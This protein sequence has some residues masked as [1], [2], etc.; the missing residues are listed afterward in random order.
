MMTAA[1]VDKPGRRWVRALIG[2][3]GPPRLIPAARTGVCTGLAVAVAVAAHRPD[4]GLVAV[5]GCFTSQYAPRD[6]GRRV[7]LTLTGIALSLSVAVLVAGLLSTHRFWAVVCTAVVAAIVTLLVPAL[8]VPPPGMAI[9]VIAA[10]VAT[11]LPSGHAIRNALLVFAAGCGCVVIAV[12]ETAVRTVLLRHTTVATAAPRLS[13]RDWWAFHIR[14]SPALLMAA[15]VGGTVLVAGFL[16]NA[17]ASA[18][19][20]SRSYWAMAAGAAA[21]GTGSHGA[22]VRLRVTHYLLGSCVGVIVAAAILASDPAPY[23]IAILLGLLMFGA[24]FVVIRSYALALVFITPLAILIAH[25]GRAGPLPALVADRLLETA[26]G[27]ACALLASLA[28]TKRWAQRQLAASST[29]TLDAIKA[30]LAANP[31]NLDRELHALRLHSTRL[32]LIR[33]R[34]SG[35]RKAVRT[36]VASALQNAAQVSAQAACLLSA[37]RNMPHAAE[38]PHRSLP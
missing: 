15:R 2:S 3:A 22:G 35:E 37:G 5:L 6:V 9:I 4:W 18:L 31:T 1:Q 29:A 36:A 14:H 25:T 17:V 23:V 13:F 7:A 12:L 32:D 10:A 8:A 20:T 33:T 26:I 38:R 21:M 27:C 24:E 28:I 11:G 19:G 30:T 34:V 16:A